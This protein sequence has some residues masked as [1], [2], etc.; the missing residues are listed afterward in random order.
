MTRL[1]E[2]L[3]SGRTVWAVGVYDALSARVA[4]AAGF[5][6]VMTGGMGVTA[7]LLGMPDAEL[8]TL[9][10]N[11]GVVSRVSR[12]LD[13]PVIADIDT[14]YGNT[15]NVMRAVADFKT[16][17][18]QAVIL[19]DQISPKRCAACV[20]DTQIIPIDEAVAKIRAARQ[21]GGDFMVVIAR[22][23][24]FDPAEAVVRAKAYVGAGADLIQPVSKTFRDFAGLRGL[25]EQCQV[26]L[27]IQILGWLEGLSPAEIER[28]AGIATFSLAAL[29]TTT[30]AL[31]ENLKALRNDRSYSAL[32][33]GRTSLA[34]FN[35]FIGFDA[36]LEDQQ[37]FY[38]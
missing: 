9:T 17:G 37:K 11:V 33:R 7:S 20:D 10:E 23:D 21:A 28:I 31:M 1:R 16:A 6:A 12:A 36:L 24:T 19:E 34:E 27:S 5:D 18:A 14:G 25:H 26:P 32:P 8:L 22:T 15:A 13:I 3:A 35:D 2:Q 38:R 30:A 29:M 4:E